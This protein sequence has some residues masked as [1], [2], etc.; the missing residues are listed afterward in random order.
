LGEAKGNRKRK[1]N[2]MGKEKK[3][4]EVVKNVRLTVCEGTS[5]VL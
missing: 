5:C 1:G 4:V 3:G 2:D